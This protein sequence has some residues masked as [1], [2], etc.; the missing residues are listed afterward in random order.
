MTTKR[1]IQLRFIMDVIDNIK[2]V[3]KK[4]LEKDQIMRDVETQLGLSAVES[5]SLIEEPLSKGILCN[6]EGSLDIDYKQRFE[7]AK[8]LVN[9]M[10]NVPLPQ[11]NVQAKS[12]HEKQTATD[13]MGINVQAKSTDVKQTATDEMDHHCRVADD[14]AYFGKSVHA[15]ILSLRALVSSRSTSDASKSP[16]TPYPTRSPLDYERIFIKSLEDRILSLEKQL[17]QKQR[18]IEKLM[19]TL[20][21]AAKKEC[22]TEKS[23][24][25]RVE[26]SRQSEKESDFMS[27]KNRTSIVYEDTESEVSS[28]IKAQRER[29]AKKKKSKKKN[30]IK[31]PSQA[32]AQ[33]TIEVEEQKNGEIEDDKATTEISMGK[34]DNKGAKNQS[35]PNKTQSS[36][37]PRRTGLNKQRKTIVV[38]DSMVKNVKAWKLKEQCEK[39]EHIYVYGK[40]MSPYSEKPTFSQLNWVFLQ[41]NPLFFF[42]KN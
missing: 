11:P 32:I 41:K 6:N 37:R 13:E 10:H 42:W 31:R 28:Q 29:R 26:K 1:D 16:T 18:I 35:S 27:S 36:P 40:R 8:S 25:C 34:K 30:A 21:L 5:H 38:R 14:I 33:S 19:E 17:D 9:F 4:K 20:K 15:E 2:R 24:E 12:T 7:L 23:Q 22:T 3:K 39:N